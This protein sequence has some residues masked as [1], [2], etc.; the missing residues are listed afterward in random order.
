VR[1]GAFLGAFGAPDTACDSGKHAP[2]LY[3]FAGGDAAF[4]ALAKAHHARCLADAGLNHPFS[5]EDQH[6][7]H[8]ERLA[9]YWAEVMGGPP[10]YSASCGTE[11]S[12]LA[13]HAGNGDMGDLG[14][15]FRDCFVHALDDAGLPTD[16][17][18]REAM[19]AYMRWAVDNGSRTRPW[20]QS[21][22][23][24]SARLG[25]TGRACGLTGLSAGCSPQELREESGCM[26]G[27]ATV[28]PPIERVLAGKQDRRTAAADIASRVGLSIDLGLLRPLERLP[29][30]EELAHA[31]GVAPITVRRAL[32]QLCDQGIL[33][34]RRGRSGGTFVAEHPPT[35]RL[36]DYEVERARLSGEILELLDY[37]LV[38]ELGLVLKAVESASADDVARL[39]GLVSDMDEAAD[40]ASFRPL[41]QG[42]HL[43]LAEIAACVRA[44]D[45][46]RRVLGRIGQLYFPYPVG[47]LRDSNSGHRAMVDAVAER[48]P[49]AAVRVV[50]R[51]I[52]HAKE[53]FAW[54]R[55]GESAVFLTKKDHPDHNRRR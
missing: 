41:D 30:D 27:V 6:P 52:D 24:G 20:T 54:M 1:D 50:E 26:K 38:L 23:Q 32:R 40:W 19:R 17:A 21:S 4:L 2:T 33:V 53:S 29:R 55:E 45:E 18:F 36:R 25:G 35:G 22:S 16:P 42:F 31:F 14:E 46:L 10:T 37:R 49:V 39:H 3:G 34:R 47:Y 28:V 15:R 44:V 43:A 8:V 48:D 9:A 51:H 13:M 7:Q 11:T 12:V 5:H